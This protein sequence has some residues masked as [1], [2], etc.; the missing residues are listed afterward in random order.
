M[1]IIS[2][3]QVPFVILIGMFLNEKYTPVMK[4][5]TFQSFV[6]LIGMLGKQKINVYFN[7]ESYKH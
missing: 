4:H 1:A 6:I 3:C 2:F 5:T 7:V